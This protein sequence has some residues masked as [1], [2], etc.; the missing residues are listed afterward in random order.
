MRKTSSIARWNMIVYIT[1]QLYW[2]EG[3]KKDLDGEEKRLIYLD[4]MCE[5]ASG[6]PKPTNS[7][8]ELKWVET[9]SLSE[10]GHVPPAVRLFRKP[11]YLK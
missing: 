10:Y 1:E 5:L 4:A 8:E 6:D 2:D 7:N 3:R 11:G 9:E